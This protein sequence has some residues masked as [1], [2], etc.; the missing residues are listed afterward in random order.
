MFLALSS[1]KDRDIAFDKISSVMMNIKEALKSNAPVLSSIK[2]MSLS[3]DA[4]P[5]HRESMEDSHITLDKFGG[6][7]FQGYFAIYDGKFV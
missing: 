6:K 1:A 2:A 7:N 5:L 4:N 3:E